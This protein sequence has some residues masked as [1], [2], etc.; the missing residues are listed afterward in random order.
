MKTKT[1]TRQRKAERKFNLDSELKSEFG[2]VLSNDMLDEEAFLMAND[3]YY[4][5]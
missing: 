3:D 1:H 5:E 2:H 4:E